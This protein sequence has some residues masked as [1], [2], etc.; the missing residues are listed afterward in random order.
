MIKIKAKPITPENFKKFGQIVTSP[1]SEPT[2]QAVDYKFWSDLAHYLVNGETEIGLC[3]V[4][5]QPTTEISGMERHTRTPEILIP[6]DAPFVVPLLRDDDPAEQTT[7]FQVNIG[8]V[9]VIDKGVWHGACLPVG[10][11]ESSYFVIF[12][13]N[14]PHED[15]EKKAIPTVEI[16]FKE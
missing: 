3:T 9:V 7:A 13:R 5:Q 1:K 14:T 15:V 6:I 10:K 4:Y 8:E 16:V 11:K 12:R 2:S